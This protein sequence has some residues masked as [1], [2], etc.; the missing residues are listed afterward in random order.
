MGLIK[1]LN[2]GLTLASGKY[3]ARM[4]ADDQASA[5]RFEKQVSFLEQNPEIGLVSTRVKLY[6]ENMHYLIGIP[7]LPV[8]HGEILWELMFANRILHPGIMVR[9]ELLVSNPFDTD[10]VTAEDYELWT[11][12]VFQTRFQ[13]LPDVTT[14][15]RIHSKN[16]SVI[17]RELQIET[18][19]KIRQKYIKQLTGIEIS[20]EEL[21]LLDAA[22]QKDIQ[23]L[24]SEKIAK[25]TSFLDQAFLILD[26]KGLLDVYSRPAVFADLG[27]RTALI[28]DQ[29]TVKGWLS[30]YYEKASKTLVANLPISLVSRVRS[31]KHHLLGKTTE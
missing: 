21:I 13:N 30:Y 20:I 23:N 17:H 18:A 10:Y 2:Y 31:I 15:M 22:C 7:H 12:L 19:Y 8:Y 5:Q 4:D 9:R 28:N 25:L 1:T 6:D 29:S 27:R 11:R 14:C 24:N 3:I 16:I 26:Q